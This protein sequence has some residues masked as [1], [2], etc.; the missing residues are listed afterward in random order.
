MATG[1]AEHATGRKPQPDK[2]TAAAINR[3]CFFRGRLLP[4]ETRD[5]KISQ[6]LD[7]TFRLLALVCFL[8]EF[9]NLLR[10][11]LDG[12]R[13]PMKLAPATALTP[14]ARRALAGIGVA[15]HERLIV[16]HVT[17]ARP[18]RLL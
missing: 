18:V 3:L 17:V 5:K 13:R 15:I 6:Q 1:T 10:A 2:S 11:P 7:L 4:V 9:L 16:S 8:D 14:L 12:V